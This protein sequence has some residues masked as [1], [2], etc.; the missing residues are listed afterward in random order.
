MLFVQII[1]DK[2]APVNGVMTSALFRK[3]GANGLS[4]Q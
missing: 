4:H 2:E 1:I 3:Y